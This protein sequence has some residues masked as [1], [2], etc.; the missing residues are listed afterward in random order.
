MRCCFGRSGGSALC[1]EDQSSDQ[2]L[3]RRYAV[4]WPTAFAEA[5]SSFRERPVI[6]AWKKNGQPLDD[7]DGPFQVIVPDDR[8]H[9]RD[10]RKAKVLEVVTP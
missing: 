10:V 5:D 2:M 6:L 3:A 7:H 8:R 4:L 1:E 9:A